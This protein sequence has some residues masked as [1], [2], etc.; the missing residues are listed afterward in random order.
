MHMKKKLILPLLILLI[1][2][3]S[4]QAIEPAGSRV[5]GM[6][7]AGVALPSDVATIFWN[8]AGLY[9]HD[10]LAMDFTFS[11][12]QFGWPQNWSF[13][14]L[15]FSK[16]QRRGAAFGLY[17]MKDL[18]SPD[19]GNAVAALLSTVYKTPIGLPV[20]LSFKYINEN[21]ADQGRTSY[22]SADLGLLLPYNSWL[23]GF[24]IQ[25]MTDPNTH[26]FPYRLLLGL[27]WKAGRKIT[28]AFQA[29]AESWND[30]ENPDQA[31]LRSG[32]EFRL[33]GAF[34]LQGGWVR[35]KAEEY[36]TGGIMLQNGNRARLSLAYHWY[37]EVQRNDRSY[38]SY[39]YYLQ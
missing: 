19:G 21:W 27:S 34:S 33:T 37:P 6:G 28:A 29:S 22:F 4:S 18:S 10:H 31:E 13:S 23:L 7:G 8:P 24:C 36:W 25:S 1:P 35:T 2:P 5:Q 38:I 15:N 16:S 12:E 20:G 3:Q 11:F 17:R 14:Y 39:S 32:L 26:L 30:L 9:Y